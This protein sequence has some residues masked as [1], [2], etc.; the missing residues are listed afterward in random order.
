MSP[1]HL[2]TFPLKDVSSHLTTLSS[3]S[4]KFYSGKHREQSET[5]TSKKSLKEFRGSLRFSLSLSLFFFLNILW[6]HLL[7]GRKAMM[8]RQCVKKQRHH[9]A[10]KGPYSQSYGFSSSHVMTVV[11]SHRCQNG[12]IKKGRAPKNRCF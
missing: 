3:K 8:N 6:N 1:L 11:V 10:N 2:R 4:L 9:F 12:T 5:K 7:L